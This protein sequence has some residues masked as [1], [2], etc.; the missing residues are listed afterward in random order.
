MKSLNLTT[1]IG[2]KKSNR[3]HLLPAKEEEIAMEQKNY[4]LY[5]KDIS[6]VIKADQA[7]MPI[8]ISF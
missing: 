6:K 4:A 3:S 1:E 7:V 2:T 5:G 8:S